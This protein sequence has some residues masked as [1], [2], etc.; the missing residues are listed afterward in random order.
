MFYFVFV[1]VVAVVVVAVVVAVVVVAVIAVVAVVSV[2]SIVSIGSVG[3]RMF[4]YSFD[5][6]PRCE[7]TFWNSIRIIITYQF[8][9]V[10]ASLV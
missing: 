3:S 6:L 8:H 9:L 7:N 4:L 1:L 10:S 5:I 2:V